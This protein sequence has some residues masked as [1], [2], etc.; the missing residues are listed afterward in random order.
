MLPASYDHIQFVLRSVFHASV[1]FHIFGTT[2][3]P[4]VGHRWPTTTG[5]PGRQNGLL[6]KNKNS[7]AHSHIPCSSVLRITFIIKI[8]DYL[9][10]VLNTFVQKWEVFFRFLKNLIILRIHSLLPCTHRPTIYYNIQLYVAPITWI[11][12]VHAERSSRTSC[13]PIQSWNYTSNT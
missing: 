3:L 13:V 4:T 10:F 8:F 6:Q 5:I 7:Q 11:I 9:I 12:I 2:P 1:D